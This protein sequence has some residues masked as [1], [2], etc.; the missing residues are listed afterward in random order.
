MDF[1]IRHPSTYSTCIAKYSPIM[2]MTRFAFKSVAMNTDYSWWSHHQLQLAPCGP[3]GTMY[4]V[5]FKKLRVLT[6]QN[7]VWKSGEHGVPWLQ[8]HI[9]LDNARFCR[10]TR[11]TGKA[12]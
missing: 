1:H 6:R 2:G 3:E 10:E 8:L 7:E 11:K 9:Q 4:L 5:E 12:S